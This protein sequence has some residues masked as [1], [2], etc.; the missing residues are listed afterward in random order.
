MGFEKG[1]E[2]TGG[3]KRGTQNRFT[4]F[5]DAL[6][7]A[8]NSEE[9]GGADGLIEWAKKPENRGEFYRLMAKLLPREIE[10]K[11]GFNVGELAERLKAARERVRR[12]REK[13]QLPNGP[14]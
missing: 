7:E 5:K 2:K 11:G 9:V 10:V 14:G 8:F 1:R 13:E 6:L 4:R 3:R 12:A